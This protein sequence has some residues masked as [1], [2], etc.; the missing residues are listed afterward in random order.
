LERINH[1]SSLLH[2]ARQ[3]HVSTLTGCFTAASSLPI[4]TAAGFVEGGI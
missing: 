3:R 2:C 4:S 1:T